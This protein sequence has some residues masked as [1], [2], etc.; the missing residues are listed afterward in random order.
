MKYDWSQQDPDL[1]VNSIILTEKL[2]HVAGPSPGNFKLPP[3]SDVD[4]DTRWE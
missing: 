2:L 4:G 3:A 1:Y